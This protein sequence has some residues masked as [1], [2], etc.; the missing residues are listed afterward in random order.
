ML[1]ISVIQ[2]NLGKLVEMKGRKT[3]RKANRRKNNS[4]KPIENQS[5][6]TSVK[7]IIDTAIKK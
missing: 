5:K 3:R 7:P 1:Y 4:R 6:L 2:M